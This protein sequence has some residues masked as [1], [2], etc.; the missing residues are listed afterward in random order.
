MS[1]E[2]KLTSKGQVT[3]PVEVRRRLGAETGDRLVFEFEGTVAKIRVVKRERRFAR[4]R[5]I[6]V[7]G[8]GKG[9]QAV[10]DL[11]RSLRDE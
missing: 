1:A 2:S 10:V 7:P 9:K 4:Y 3:I 6:G 5:G 8:L 11:V